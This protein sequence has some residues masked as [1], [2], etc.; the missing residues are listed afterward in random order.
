LKESGNRGI[1]SFLWKSK[2]CTATTPAGASAA[3]RLE[4]RRLGVPDA[5]LERLNGRSHR[6]ERVE[7]LAIGREQ[8]RS[9]K[10]M[11]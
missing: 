10:S 2:V 3:A 7:Q 1:V 5:S 6:A 11:T 9:R 4:R 8:P